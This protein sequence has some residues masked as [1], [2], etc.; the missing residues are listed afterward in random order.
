MNKRIQTILSALL[1]FAFVPAMSQVEFSLEL[2][3]SQQYELVMRAQADWEG[4]SALTSTGQVTIVAPTGGFELTNLESQHGNWAFN[5]RVNAPEE[6]PDFDYLT[7]GMVSLGTDAIPYKKGEEVVLFTFE[8]TGNC[9]GA[10]KL[11]ENNDAF[12][13][14][15][16]QKINVGNQ[17]TTLGGGNQNAWTGNFTKG[18]ANCATVINTA[19]VQT[20]NA[21]NVEFNIQEHDGIVSIAMVPNT[22]FEGMHAFTS[23]AQVTVVAPAGKV[24]ISNFQNVSGNW[25]NN[26]TVRAPQENPNFDYFTFGLLN[27]GTADIAYQ[28]NEPTVLF[29]FENKGACVGTIELMETSDPFMTPNSQRINVGN[30]VTLLGAGNRNA[31]SSNNGIVEVECNVSESDLE[32]DQTPVAATAPLDMG[33]ELSKYMTS[34]VVPTTFTPNNDGV[35]DQLTIKGLNSI[36]A[37]EV[38]IFDQA[39]NLVYVQKDATTPWNGTLQN[40]GQ[41]AAEGTYFYQISVQDQQSFERRSLQGFIELRR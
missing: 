12:I 24:E 30:Q 37:T 13:A 4:K 36:F 28:A 19:N 38:S 3:K 5:S 33:S 15:N 34:M 26:S 14:P 20:N 32:T 18:H 6:N 2:T 25:S 10:L 29:T 9:T 16:S 1:I 11:M 35:N 41:Q 27:L 7:I 23:T 22:T 21:A 31:W 17:L 40:N 8:N 39:G